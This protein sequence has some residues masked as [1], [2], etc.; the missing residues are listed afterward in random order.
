[1]T[2]PV[3]AAQVEVQIKYQGYIERQQ[4]EVARRDN[5]D[6]VRLPA[7]CDYS[8]I[9][10]LSKEIQQKLAR[11]QPENLGQASRISGVTPA[12]IALLL[13]YLK[14]HGHL[15]KDPATA[16]THHGAD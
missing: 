9:P 2:D 3:V 1:M 7:G 12:A 8:N 15:L 14:K 16:E 10:G 5:L 6:Q 13:V 4:D 11:Q